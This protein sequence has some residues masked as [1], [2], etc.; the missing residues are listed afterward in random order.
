MVIRDPVGLIEIKSGTVLLRQ[1]SIMTSIAD[2]LTDVTQRIA[3]SECR[4]AEQQQR[5][6]SGLCTEAADAAI[7]LYMTVTTLRELRVY[8]AR[9]EHLV[10]DGDK[11]SRPITT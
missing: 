5:I 4:I 1:S 7:M 10:A 2:K 8:K 6:S 9:L 11:I 3:E